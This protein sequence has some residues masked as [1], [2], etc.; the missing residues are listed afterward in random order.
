MKIKLT[1]SQIKRLI[2]ADLYYG[3]EKLPELIRDIQKD[4]AEGK[5]YCSEFFNVL[6]SLDINSIVQNPMDTIT[7][8]KKMEKIHKIIYEKS[9]KYYKTLNTFEND[10]DNE[11][12]QQFDSLNSN[13]DTIQNDMENILDKYKEIIEIF[14][15]VNGE[16]K[17]EFTYYENE[18]PVQS[19]EITKNMVGLQ[20]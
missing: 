11:H 13:Y 20:N 6:K 19:F 18:Y 10:F 9:N 7:I 16:M 15:E 1:E 8:I 3:D 17:N 5:K 12:L 4:I 14:V 2:E